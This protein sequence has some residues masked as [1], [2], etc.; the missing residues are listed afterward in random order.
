MTTFKTR[1]EIISQTEGVSLRAQFY[2]LAGNAAD[3]S[4]FPQVTIIQ[5]SGNVVVG[6]TSAGVYRLSTGLYGFDYVI[7]INSNLGVWADVWRG[8]GSDGYVQIKEYNFMVQNTQMPMVNLDG[9]ESLGDDVGFQYSQTAIRNINKL[10]KTVRARLNSAG[11]SKSYDQYGNVIYSDCDIFSVETLTSFIATSLT[12]FNQIP[13]FTAFTFEDTEVI[14]NFFEV[15]VQGAVIYALASK[16]LIERGREFQISDN[17]I[18][19][20]PPTVSELLNTQWST[21]ISNHFEKLK[22]IKASMKPGPLG[23]G[24]MSITSSRNPAIARLRHLR[25]RQLL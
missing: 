24:T 9:Y 6:P 11:K 23:L 12:D 15:I 16:A 3:L 22:L 10:M 18:N 13:H 17:G 14:N 4:A 1:G 25:A 7:S 19:F 20:T 2:D 21:E 8:T 5:P